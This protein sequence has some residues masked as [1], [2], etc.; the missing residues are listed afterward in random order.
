MEEKELNDCMAYMDIIDV[1]IYEKKAKEFV[2][3]EKTD[4]TIEDAIAYAMAMGFRMG[5]E[6]Y[7]KKITEEKE[8]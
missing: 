6:A 7:K 4:E 8:K 3:K 2:E 1:M 5:W